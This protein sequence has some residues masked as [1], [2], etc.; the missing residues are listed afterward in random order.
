MIGSIQVFLVC[1]T[2]V[3]A[4]GA[5]AQE[6]FSFFQASTPES[7][8]RMLKL[9]NL[10][11][12]DVIVDLGSG[13][14]LIVLTAAK[15]NTKLRGWGVDIDQK[16]IAESNGVAKAQGVADRIKFFHQNAFDADL[17]E[18]TVITLWLFPELMR[19]LRPIIFE[20]ARPGTRVLTSTWDF[21]TW[22]ADT[23]DAGNPSIHL[24]T[25]PARVAGNWSWELSLANQHVAYAAVL[26]QQFQ[27][28]E[29]VVRAGANREVLTDVKLTGENIS[30][31]LA[32]TLE[33]LGLT[34]HEFTGKIRGEQID[35][36]AQLILPEGNRL[37][38]PWR[39]SRTPASD[40]F[41]PT[42]ANIP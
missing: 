28:A 23:I 16:L 22:P 19:L 18:A 30:F 10:R 33:G 26:D 34:R 11:D 38:L 5:F 7:V 8:E 25:V 14:G 13:D 42:G 21:G 12:D 41:A 4:A 15:L 20:R 9:A 31:N 32:M 39:A 17:R 27:A 29:G 37:E 2:I 35:G 1:L 3:N 24:W 6:R 36:T 40:Y